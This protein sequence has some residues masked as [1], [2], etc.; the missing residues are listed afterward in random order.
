[1]YGPALALRAY[2]PHEQRQAIER[3]LS[4][5][6]VL[7]GV[8]FILAFALKA[9]SIGTFP[10]L[11]MFTLLS[12]KIAGLFF[13][14]FS[15]S[16]L[17]VALEALHRS[18]YF[19]GLEQI[20]KE[21]SDPGSVLVGWG[22]ATI[23]AETPA[24]DVVGAFLESGFGQEI[25][26]R[27]GI[28]EE[29]FGQYFAERTNHLDAD[30]FFV[31]KDGPV[32]LA[33]YV[34]SIYKQ[35]AE[36]RSFLSSHNVNA[37]QLVRAAS[38]VTQIER[39]NR[40]KARFWSRD[41]LGR[42]PG[43]GKTWGY[44]ETYL[45]EKYGH[46]LTED[47][48]WQAALMGRH[49]EQDEVEDME[50][51][52]ARARQANALVVGDDQSM[53]RQR[54]AQLYHKIREGEVLPPLEAKR[55][56]LLDI[57]SVV[58]ATHDKTA[59][60]NSIHAIL[61]QALSAGNII[62]YIERF[63]AAIAGAAAVS[64]DLVDLLMPCFESDAIQIIVATDVDGFNARISRDTR[65]MQGFDVVRM[66]DIASEGILLLLEQRAI[67]REHE[68]GVVFTIPALDSIA[69]LAD[70]FFPTGVMPDKAF[71]L[72]EELIPVALSAHLEQVVQADVEQ[73]VFKKTG[74]PMG[75]PTQEE[76]TKLLT[77][78][79]FLHKRVV[80][81]QDAVAAVAKAL[82]RARAG[83]GSA[84]RPMGSFLFL[85]PTGVG[86]TETAKALAEA[87]FNDEDAM[88]RLD[89]SEFQGPEAL[90]ELIGSFDT[91]KPGR[92]ANMI[93]E[94]QYGV[95]LLDEFE[96][97]SR[98]VHDL[99]LQVLDEGMFTDAAGKQVNA[100]NLI[101]IATSNAG[102]SLIW[103]WEKD[104]KDVAT[105]KSELID[106]LVKEGLFRPEFL[107]RFDDIIV[108]HPLKQDEVRA[109]A[110]IQLTSLAKHLN[111][112]RN[113]TLTVSDELTDAMAKVGYDP[114]FGGRPMRRAIKDKVEQAVADKILQ[115]TL[116]PG[117]T[118]SLT[119]EDVK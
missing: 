28:R 110:K 74:V 47:H 72:L 29:D 43:I 9:S 51:I 85:G 17:F 8:L 77:L 86:K 111:D 70:R 81:Q 5:V 25:L 58:T 112:E 61:N 73:L 42:I 50:Q 49:S 6:T 22:V 1:M 94:K 13:I 60:E 89:M 106:H 80:G 44:G 95:L 119:A 4:L 53:I 32:T 15:L 66:K 93:R 55:V 82:R 97:S 100:R 54:V 88:N 78:E 11:S 26:Y 102:A 62:L 19:H 31:E 84:D 68:T 57:E 108:F 59:F 16:Y 103:D 96:K 113:I 76:R 116:K 24:H 114:K 41:N 92:L 36:L 107:N 46:D 91:G 105:H 37:E 20:L 34:K 52:L 23:I 90:D 3:I 56:F 45:L 99:F 64:V 71:D 33:T 48:M 35:D 79:D 83:V 101:I 39:A 18:Y 65:V 38:W 7:L 12:N 67:A 118:L 30:T 40:L 27:A 21:S 104:S 75:D 10:I 87:L 115:G 14:S 2:L 63:S 98:H 109:I 117:G 69:R